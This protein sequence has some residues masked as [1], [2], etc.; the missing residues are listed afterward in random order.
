MFITHHIIG[1]VNDVEGVILQVVLRLL[2]A[3]TVHGT[4]QPDCVVKIHV[5]NHLISSM[6]RKKNPFY[7]E[8]CRLVKLTESS[9]F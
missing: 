1:L 7:N 2:T 6:K 9:V 4:T 3:I 5:I 8:K